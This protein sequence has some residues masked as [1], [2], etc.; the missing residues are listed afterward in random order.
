MRWL[1]LIGLILTFCVSA[2]PYPIYGIAAYSSAPFSA[3][4]ADINNDGGND[5]VVLAEDDGTD[6]IF[7]FENEDILG[8]YGQSWVEH[9]IDPVGSQYFLYADD[10]DGANYLDIVYG[11]GTG[12]LNNGSADDWTPFSIDIDINPVGTADING[13]S[14]VD[15]VYAGATTG[16][17]Y[18]NAGNGTDWTAHTDTFGNK[19]VTPLDA[20]GDGD[21][22]VLTMFQ[23]QFTPWQFYV[24]E[25]VDGF[26]ESW[27]E[28]EVII[29]DDDINASRG[30]AVLDA[31]GNTTAD[32]CVAVIGATAGDVL[33]LSID[34]GAST[35]TVDEGTAY[36]TVLGGDFD[37]DG[38]DEIVAYDFTGKITYMFDDLMTSAQKTEM[39]ADF[40]PLCVGDINNDGTDDIIGYS[41][42]ESALVY[43]FY[44]EAPSAFNLL[45][46]ADGDT[47][48]EPVALD[49]EDAEDVQQVTY[50]LWYSTEP[51]FA[52][53][54]VI[55][56]LTD[57]TYTYP[58][59]ALTP[60]ETYYW[61]VA[62]TDGFEETW[63]GPDE[64]WSFT[65]E[66]PFAGIDITSFTAE[67]V[68]DGVEVSWECADEVAGFNLYR[69][70]KSGE[71]DTKAIT[72]RDRLNAELITG[73]SPYEYVDT[74][75]ENGITYSYWLEAIDVGGSSETLG[76]VEC[77][78]RGALPTAYALYQSKPNPAPGSATI[79][80][81]LPETAP[82]TLTV[83]D[84]T[85]RKVA[86]VVNET[87]TAGEHAAEV[88]GL[89]PGVYVYRMNAGS[90]MAARKMVVLE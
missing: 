49:W 17:W 28:Y 61:K 23:Y 54:D 70:V 83:Y 24:E 44:N 48:G 59:G 34:A 50:D 66:D 19:S 10:L 36:S 57:S 18:E 35:V 40:K 46:P 12:Y 84:L 42:T 27:N 81:D 52:T 86:T 37:G 43:A 11:N 51:T 5:I 90:F 74:A 9:Q 41:T 88:S 72:S 38:L 15:V 75:V 6:T 53:Y 76:P 16:G 63:S 67:S 30:V 45:S 85:G 79:A 82:V 26:G 33:S 21:W 39:Q 8:T 2:A 78:W 29:I 7:W 14:Y 69:S 3:T 77:T 60:G 1:T 68:R 32:I 62:V 56:G 58:E 89:A 80:F 25:N 55:T 47:V 73:A 71:T 65:V 13:D 31:D 87:L 22:D 20:E 4:V 64:Y